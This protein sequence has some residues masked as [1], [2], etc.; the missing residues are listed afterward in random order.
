MSAFQDQVARDLGS[1]FLPSIAGRGAEF[2]TT[3]E[4]DGVPVACILDEAEAEHNAEG[5]SVFDSV[6]YARAADLAAPVVDQRMAVG[7]RQANVVHVDEAQDLRVIKLRWW[8]S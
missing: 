8:T 1:V 7:D 4:I 5:V 2:E 3:V 6:L